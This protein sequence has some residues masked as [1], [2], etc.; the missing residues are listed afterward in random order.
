[1]GSPPH[2]PCFRSWR[3]AGV[4]IGTPSAPSRGRKVWRESLVDD[5]RFHSP[6]GLGGTMLGAVEWVLHPN[7]MGS[8]FS[9][10]PVGQGQPGWTART[11]WV[12]GHMCLPQAL[13]LMLILEQRPRSTGK[14]GN[15]SAKDEPWEPGHSLLEACIYR[16]DSRVACI[17]IQGGNGVMSEPWLTI[18]PPVGDWGERPV[19]SLASGSPGH[20]WLVS[21]LCECESVCMC[22]WEGVQPSWHLSPSGGG[23][24]FCP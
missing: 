8:A 9:S 5:S 7:P 18:I 13:P 15:V 24:P 14:K 10:W 21:G 4:H 1:M 19:T 12:A 11:S 16:P 20:M 17:N 2:S 23:P 3:G 6:G 22:V